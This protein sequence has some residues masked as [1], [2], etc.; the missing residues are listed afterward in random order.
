MI[1]R[2]QHVDF[3]RMWLYILHILEATDIYVTCSNAPRDAWVPSFVNFSSRVV[4]YTSHML[5]V[6]PSFIDT[7]IIRL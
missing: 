7:Q 3:F 4:L 5:K 2:S 1:H 6:H